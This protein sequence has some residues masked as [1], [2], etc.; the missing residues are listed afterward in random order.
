[1][2]FCE[3][4]LI[5][6]TIQ[7]KRFVIIGF[8]L[9]FLGFPVLGQ[10]FTEWKDIDE[11]SLNLNKPHCN[12]IPYMNDRD[13]EK[14]SYRTSPYYQSLNGT[15]KYYPVKNLS[16]LSKE[17]IEKRQYESVESANVTVPGITFSGKVGELNKLSIFSSSAIESN[18][19][20]GI[21]SLNFNV[22]SEWK[23]HLVFLNFESVNAAFYVWINEKFV[24]Y[25]ENS[26][27]PSEFDITPHI[28]LGKENTL[29][30]LAYHLSDG[31][32]LDFSDNL[33]YNGISQNVYLY[34]KPKT[35]IVNYTVE[36]KLSRDYE[37]GMLDVNIELRNEDKKAGYYVELEL[38][39]SRGRSVDRYFQ[40]VQMDKNK[41]EQIVFNKQ[42]SKA[43]KWT[44]ESPNLYTVLI[45]IKDVKGQ[46]I[47][48]T[49]ERI[50]F[51]NIEVAQGRILVNGT[52][53]TLKGINYSLNF[54]SEGRPLSETAMINDIKIMKTHNF[55][56]VQTKNGP[57]SKRFYEL[58]DE[59]GIYVINTANIDLKHT[60]F[61]KGQD[62]EGIIL[63]RIENIYE[64]DKN[65]ASIIAWSLGSSV[66]NGVIFNNAYKWLKQNDRSRLVFFAAAGTD[67]NT[68]V[69]FPKHYDIESSQKYLNQR[70]NRPLIISALGNP[71][72]NG[73][74]TLA[75]YRDLMANNSLLQ[76][77]FIDEFRGKGIPPEIA[78]SKAPAEK[79]LVAY[80]GKIF[81]AMKELKSIFKP[82][83]VRAINIE[84]GEFSVENLFDFNSFKDY[85]F[86]YVIF[87]NFKEKGIIEGE[88]PIA[89]QPGERANVKIRIPEIFTYGGE[90]YSIRFYLLQK[91]DSPAIRKGTE[92]GYEDFRIKTKVQEK[93]ELANYDYRKLEVEEKEN[94][95]E[96]TNGEFL[97]VFDT[98][99]G[100]IQSLAFNEEPII[101]NFSNLQFQRPKTFGEEISTKRASET[102]KAADN[103]AYQLKDLKYKQQNEYTYLIDVIFD[104]TDSWEG[105]A[106]MMDLSQS[107]IILGNGD[108][109]LDNQLMI[110][111][112]NIELSK[113]G[114][115]VELSKTLFN[116]H[117][118][119]RETESY[120]DRK[121]GAKTGVYK[122]SIG[123]LCT[124][125]AI[126]Q[127][128]GNRTD[129]RWVAFTDSTKGL[130][131]DFVD[132]VFD[133]SIYPYSSNAILTTS[134]DAIS[135]TTLTKNL[136]HENF[137]TLNMDYQ[138]QGIGVGN[139]E[140][141]LPEK[142]RIKREK[143]HFTVHIRPFSA[144]VS[145]PESFR[146]NAL[147][148]IQ[149]EVLPMPF[150]TKNRERFDSTMSITLSS[151]IPNT[152]IYYTLDDSEPTEKSLRYNVPFNIKS[153]T[154]V[155]A[156]LFASGKTPSFTAKKSFKYELIR[157]VT[158]TNQ[159]N[160]P[161]NK[162]VETMLIDGNHGN[163][164]FKEEDW[165][166]F[167]QNDFIAEVELKSIT[168]LKQLHVVLGHDPDSWV[169]LPE[170]IQVSVSSDGQ[171]YT[172]PITFNMPFDSKSENEGSKKIEDISIP[173]N[174]AQ[175][176][177]IRIQAKNIGKIPSWHRAKGLNSWILVSEIEALENTA[178]SK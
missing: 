27:M 131:I 76:G 61:L 17:F 115:Q 176:K 80:D 92:L 73:F 162:N 153:S 169:F 23:N 96:I 7:M 137:W 21:Y 107:Y 57:L 163:I 48:L 1:M 130:F 122:D 24:G 4:Q 114:W 140:M 112:K 144:E 138:K 160:T 94:S 121:E 84:Q 49:G 2:Y 54:D 10:T 143:Y 134:N 37:N 120:R 66:E 16:E 174:Q 135:T 20:A 38:L 139:T 125:Y 150:I 111:E 129:T 166:G 168:H 68:D 142:Y 26:I 47:E 43:E 41:T 12:V 25:S 148:I 95:I 55:N 90:E 91:N 106:K 11:N 6:T 52:Q 64:R 116:A 50:G 113:I 3:S 123:N 87:S 145:N 161:Y 167:S 71:F 126:A 62:W 157:S 74:G 100:V 89:A 132:T 149:N 8:L 30:V 44:A 36:S 128:N 133:F 63:D 13:V 109:L 78:Y 56:A 58:C 85:R 86:G 110:Q 70:P 22:T 175:V 152:T 19:S 98:K 14:L 119:G 172:E 82:F 67:N 46:I 158:L 31:T 104:V 93:Q 53:V 156:R 173:L 59:Y 99:K 60:S 28:K 42:I 72:G 124:N 83:K 65:H 108:I 88:V 171:T 9:S 33:L 159:S 141:E 103:L 170:N 45:R 151:P 79:G 117:W 154:T 40:W 39:D 118:F 136:K 77:I 34:A 29:T 102:A 81:P 155:K 97:L 177:Y 178:S 165:L 164:D 147:P 18:N 127:E 35:H 5:I 101:T 105:G 75:E 32:C 146:M 15:W 69:F 51:R